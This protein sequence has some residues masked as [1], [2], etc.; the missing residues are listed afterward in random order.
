MFLNF[1]LASPYQ[2]RSYLKVKMS[3]NLAQK[4][5]HLA[6]GWFVIKYS[7]KLKAEIGTFCL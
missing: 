5:S 7:H 6:T 3:V 4:A 2:F 1:F